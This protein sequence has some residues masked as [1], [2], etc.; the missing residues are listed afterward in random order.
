[1]LYYSTDGTNFQPYTEAFTFTEYTTV[2]AYIIDGTHCSEL[3]S[4]N[5]YITQPAVF[6]Q[7]LTVNSIEVSEKN[8][9]DVLEDKT[10]SY[11]YKSQT[12]ILNN[13]NIVAKGDGITCN[14]G[15][16]TIA[17][18]GTNQIYYMGCG[19]MFG[20]GGAEENHLIIQGNS[21]D[22]KL[23]INALSDEV[24]LAGLYAYIANVTV[25]NCT[26]V[27]NQGGSAIFMKPSGMGKDGMLSIYDAQVNLYGTNSAMTNIMELNLSGVQIL[28]PVGAY[29]DGKQ[30]YNI[31]LDVDGKPQY[32]AT[33]IIGPEPQQELPQITENTDVDFANDLVDGNTG[34]PVDLNNTVINDVYYNLSN[35]YDT[36][37]SCFTLDVT[38]SAYVDDIIGKDIN[39]EMVAAQYNGM[40]IQVGGTGKIVVSFATEGT[41]QLNVR[42][43]DGT[44]GKFSSEYQSDQIVN[45]DTKNPV[46]VYIY[47]TDSTMD[48]KPGMMRE[49]ELLGSVKIYGL[50]IEPEK[51]ITGVEDISISPADAPTEH[52]IFNINGVRCSEPL[53][54]GFYI[55]DGRKVII[56]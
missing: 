35:T 17:V 48:K 19:I 13:T 12:L 55:I 7:T 43:G 32:Q 15:V 52:I 25:T 49:G 41:Q 34:D 18:N 11:D 42:I 10:V 47:A 36:K 20:G 21:L 45:Y 6:T 2:S 40:I 24:S 5:Y 4:N 31:N 26:L 23:V 9:Y 38:S 29:F 46:Y 50:S 51:V 53:A 1:T 33:C 56:R 39:D 27:I 28:Q 14:G 22:D 3:V 54:P 30:E 16:L 37:E 44:P 8:C